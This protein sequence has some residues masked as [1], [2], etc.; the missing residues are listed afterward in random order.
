[1][2]DQKFSFVSDKRMIHKYLTLVKITYGMNVYG[3]MFF[4]RQYAIKQAAENHLS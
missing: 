3:K 4:L 2:E 1:M